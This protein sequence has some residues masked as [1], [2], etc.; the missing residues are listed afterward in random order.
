MPI[1][2]RLDLMSAA[3]DPIPLLPLVIVPQ[4]HA[5]SRGWFGETFRDKR[6]RN[7]G[8]ACTFVQDNQS[9]STRRGTLRGF[10]FQKPPAAQAKLISVLHGRILDVA[11]DI[12]RDS[13]T[14]GGYVSIDLS[15]DNGKQL[16]VPTGFAH[17]FVTL[18]DDV[19]VLYKVSD[20]YA[21]SGEGGI[22]WDDPDIAFPWPLPGADIILSE[23]DGRWPFLADLESPFPYD[24]NPLT[25]LPAFDLI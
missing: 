17:G 25:E 23:R 22:R 4:R 14:Y 6:L 12:R 8:I 20:Y 2:S 13:P 11:V 10:H 7:L 9:R 16:F 18:E 1:F 5:D 3:S 21:P 19:S 24:G 15:S